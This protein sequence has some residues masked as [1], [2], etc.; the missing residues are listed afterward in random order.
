M[1]IQEICRQTGLTRKAVEYYERQ[2]LI[3][4][5]RLASGYRD[6]GEAELARLREIAVLRACRIPV[7]AIGEILS[8]PAPHRSALLRQYRQLHQL[9]AARIRQA[10]RLL[11]RLLEH[12]DIPAAFEAVQ[13]EGMDGDTLREKL[14]FAFPGGYGLLLALH[15]GRFLDI[16]LE[17]DEQQTAY[18]AIVD[19]LDRLPAQIPPELEERLQANLQILDIPA[20]E[21]VSRQ[22]IDRMLEDPD[23]Y[24]AENRADLDAYLAYRTSDAFWQSEEG[25]LYRLMLDFQKESGYRTVFLENLKRLSPAYRQYTER[26]QAANDR[27]LALYPEAAGIETPPGR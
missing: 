17:T 6:Y 21:E 14:L 4:P 2:G 5:V 26:L 11:D 15:F 13:T 10:D 24:L 25:K 27:L 9:E 19:Y 8:A 1:R 16:P 7:A 18:R 22:A 23:R 12:Y 20:M 3:A